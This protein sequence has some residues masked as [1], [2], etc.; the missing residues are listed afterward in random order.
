MLKVTTA[1]HQMTFIKASSR[2][3]AKQNSFVLGRDLWGT[4]FW[5][6]WF[7]MWSNWWVMWKL[8]EKHVR[9]VEKKRCAGYYK[10]L[11]RQ[12]SGKEMERGIVGDGRALCVCGRE[13]SFIQTSWELRR[14]VKHSQRLI[15]EL[16]AEIR[17]FCVCVC[18]YY[19]SVFV[20]VRVEHDSCAFSRDPSVS[21]EGSSNDLC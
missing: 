18:I 8:L 4:D 16:I 5:N 6:E 13:S 9:W 17:S 11:W 2:E 1:L 3:K 7:R 21:R 19:T 12:T 15:A 14:F 10:P 20:Y